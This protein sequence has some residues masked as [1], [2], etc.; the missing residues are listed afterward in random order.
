M[1]RLGGST[2]QRALPL[3][4]TGSGFPPKGQARGAPA[5]LAGVMDKG[6]VLSQGVSVEDGSEGDPGWRGRNQSSAPCHS[7]FQPTPPRSQALINS[8]YSFT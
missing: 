2:C 3:L 1:T 6:C 5:A 8:L 7:C 4:V